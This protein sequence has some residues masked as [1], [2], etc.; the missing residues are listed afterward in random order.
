M[1]SSAKPQKE[2]PRR[3][4]NI[5]SQLIFGWSIPLLYKGSRQG[6]N[7]EDLT[8]CLPEDCSEELG[9]ALERLV[10]LLLLFFLIFS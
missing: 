1:D 10:L 4:A 6:L 8:K 9:D 5:L 7:T 2:N 3:Y